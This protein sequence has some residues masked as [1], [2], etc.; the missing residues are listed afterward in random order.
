MLHC[1]W[2][3]VHEQ[4]ALLRFLFCSVGGDKGGVRVN[5]GGAVGEGFALGTSKRLVGV[6][7]WASRWGGLLQRLTPGS[8]QRF[9][10]AVVL[11]LFGAVRNR[12]G[13]VVLCGGGSPLLAVR[14]G[15]C[16]G[17]GGQP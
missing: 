9:S 12:C 15:S 14:V 10:L 1:L 16:H 6:D 5:A 11:R 17:C 4:F 3:F 13:S 8:R 7:L 2:S